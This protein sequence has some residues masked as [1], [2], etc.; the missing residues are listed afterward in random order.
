MTRPRPLS[1]TP[2]PPRFRL[3]EKNLCTSSVEQDQGS[4]LTF[5]TYPSLLSVLSITL[6]VRLGSVSASVVAGEDQNRPFETLHSTAATRTPSERPA[7]PL[8]CADPPPSLLYL[9]PLPASHTQSRSRP[10]HAWPAPPAR[11]QPPSPHAHMVG[12]RGGSRA[13]SLIRCPE[14]A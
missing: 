14:S 6:G 13:P 5:T 7:A 2:I 4:P 12:L 11:A 1:H 9:G 10:A 3:P 8:A